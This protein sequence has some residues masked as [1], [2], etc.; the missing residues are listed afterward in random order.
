MEWGADY[1]Y[2]DE[3]PYAIVAAKGMRGLVKY[4]GSHGKPLR[5]LA[6]E[7]RWQ[8]LPSHARTE[9]LEFPKW[10]KNFIRQNRAFYSENRKWIEPWIASI[11]RFPSSLQKFEW[12]IHG[13]KRDVWEYVLQFRASGV[14]VKRRNTAPSLIAMTDTQVPIIGWERRYMTPKECA[15]LQ[16]LGELKALPSSSTRAFQALGNAVNADVVET[17]ARALLRKRNDHSGK[18]SLSSGAEHESS[19]VEMTTC[20]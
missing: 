1:P 18:P 5:E 16:S 13:E 17:V 10:K 9:Q 15:R 14:R 2:E 8:G 19:V 11:L 7:D 12:N 4:R 6:G 3:T 20:L